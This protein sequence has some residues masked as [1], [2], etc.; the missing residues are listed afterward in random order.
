[1]VHSPRDGSR[2]SKSHVSASYTE[3]NVSQLGAR[4]VMRLFPHFFPLCGVGMATL[5][6]HDLPESVELDRQAMSAVTG[7]SMVQTRQ[8]LFV[9]RHALTGLPRT[10]FAGLHDPAL[11]EQPDKPVLKTL[12]R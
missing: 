12:L 8:T 10:V 7:G 3:S 4:C 9:R 5:V 6:I 11:S 2:K 1:M